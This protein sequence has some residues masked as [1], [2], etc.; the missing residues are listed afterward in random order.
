MQLGLTKDQLA[1]RRN[2]LGGSDS[3]TIMSGNDERIY[4][5]WQEKRGEVGP[6]DLSDV[7][8]VLMGSFTEPFNAYWFEKQ[9]GLKITNRGEERLSLEYPWMAATLDGLVDEEGGDIAVWE[10][11][12]V[13]AF[14]KEAEIIARYTPQLHHNMIV[15]ETTRA[16][17][18]VFYGTLKWAAHWVDFD[19]IYAEALLDAER[20][21]WDCVA[22]GEP[23]VAGPVIAPPVEAVRVVDMGKSNSWASAA[24][25][26]LHHS[27]AA[28]SFEAA[29]KVIKELIEPD[30][31]QAF[32]HGIVA[33]RS[34]SGALTI[35]K[36]K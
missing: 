13:S 33:S 36:A 3:N 22:S 15:T 27:A 8:P 2:A 29:T 6:E 31:Q 5:L 26:W 24:V 10:A 20:L 7:L 21:F 16:V 34:K 23:P 19:P 9:T 12:H 35:R 17:L 25:D 28:K 1:F 18:S 4:R 32:G 30:V 14:A 11:K